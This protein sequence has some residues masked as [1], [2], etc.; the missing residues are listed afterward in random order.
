MTEKN[1]TPNWRALRTLVFALLDEMDREFDGDFHEVDGGGY[2]LR[3]RDAPERLAVALMLYAGDD[4]LQ[5]EED[6]EAFERF[7]LAI[8]PRALAGL[9]MADL[10]PY[11]R[12]WLIETGWQT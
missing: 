9:S 6:L 4:P 8:F 10:T 5:K 7:Y 3:D 1:F 12:E 2:S 11:C